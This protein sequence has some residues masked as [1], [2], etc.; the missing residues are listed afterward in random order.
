MM[1][2][3]WEREK[4]N[5]GNSI[6]KICAQK[7][8]AD[9]PKIGDWLDRNLKKKKKKELWQLNCDCGKSNATTTNYFIIFSQIVVMTNFLL[10]L[11]RGHQ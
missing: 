5:S 8:L 10:V 9:L 6:A 1:W 4:R 2:W 7:N 3:K 11:I